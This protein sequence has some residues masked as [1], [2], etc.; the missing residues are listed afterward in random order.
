MSVTPRLPDTKNKWKKPEPHHKQ[1]WIIWITLI[2]ISLQ[3]LPLLHLKLR[4]LGTWEPEKWRQFSHTCIVVNICLD[5]VILIVISSY[6][7]VSLDTLHHAA[8]LEVMDGTLVVFRCLSRDHFKSS[9][10]ENCYCDVLLLLLQYP[11]GHC[12]SLQCS[13]EAWFMVIYILIR[14]CRYEKSICKWL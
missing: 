1:K 13:L 2:T 3:S 14:F 10:V 4:T 7:C 6:S 12:L 9:R 8:Q 11:H 5:Q